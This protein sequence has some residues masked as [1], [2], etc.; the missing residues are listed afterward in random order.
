MSIAAVIVVLVAVLVSHFSVS[1][2]FADAVELTYIYDQ[3]SLESVAVDGDDAVILRRL[4]HGIRYKDSPSCGFTRD[5]SIR[6]SDG[7][8]EITLYPALD[9]DP[10]FQIGDSDYYINITEKS[11]VKVDAVLAKYGFTFPAV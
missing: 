2:R 7:D 6:F 1:V 3:K 5:I 8:R 4:I 11:K 10:I 9:G